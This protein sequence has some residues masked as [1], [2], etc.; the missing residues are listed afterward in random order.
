MTA[1]AA[2]TAD[3]GA[4]TQAAV[5]RVAIAGGH[6]IIRGVV[7]LSCGTVPG[8]SIVA[9]GA[10]TADVLGFAELDPDLLVLD[11]DLSD[12]DGLDAL[13]A[14]REAGFEGA[15]LAISDR[16]DGNTVLDALKLG[17]LGYL[18]KSD[19]LRAVGVAMN[20]IVSGER[21]ISSELE[22]AALVALHRFA[23]QAR[24]GSEMNAKLTP[25]ERQIL[26]MISDGLT[27]QQMARR[28]SISPR[29][30][31]TH[32]AKLYRKL[33]VKTRVQAVSRAAS[34]GLIDLGVS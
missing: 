5:T 3:D 21:L 23:R 17:A 9:E 24:E 30:V 16:T 20:R 27:M 7:R 31:E 34:L 25:R 13:R 29:T 10:T 8:A 11:L 19:D 26:E 14:L 32:V 4:A 1:R 12:G 18:N 15:V 33:G 28:L 2:L 22:Q 6:P